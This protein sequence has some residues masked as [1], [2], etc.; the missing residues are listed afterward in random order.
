MDPAK[1]AINIQIA[2][3]TEGLQRLNASTRT[4][5]DKKDPT[6]INCLTIS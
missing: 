1:Q 4:D 5:E 2:V 6:K 3:G